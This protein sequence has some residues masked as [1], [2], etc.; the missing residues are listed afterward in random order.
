VASFGGLVGVSLSEVST[1]AGLISAVRK[2]VT[3]LALELAGI[4]NPSADPQKT[5]EPFITW[6]IWMSI[7]LIAILCLPA[8]FEKDA[9][10]SGA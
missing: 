1:A 5:P 9:K 2:H 3:A 10:S 8:F 4:A 6:M 7:V